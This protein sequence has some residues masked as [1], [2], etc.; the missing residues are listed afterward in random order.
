MSRPALLLFHGAPAERALLLR[1]AAEGPVVT[2][3]LDLADRPADGAD[4]QAQELGAREHRRLDLRQE[5]FERG[6]APLM[7]LGA[8][9][10]GDLLWPLA[11]EAVGLL[12]AARLGKELEAR[13]LAAA[14]SPARAARCERAW[15]ALAPDR[16]RLVSATSTTTPDPELEGELWGRRVT[17]PGLEDLWEEPALDELFGDAPSPE[18]ASELVEEIDLELEEGVLAGASGGPQDGPGLV[19]LLGRVG[20]RHALGQRL[21]IDE[22]EQGARR[23]LAV[24]APAAAI[25]EAAHAALEAA[26]LSARRRALKEPLARGYRELLRRGEHHAP[27]LRDVEAFLRSQQRPVSG[28]VRLKLYRGAALA[29]G[30]QPA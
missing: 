7:R 21:V 24:E 30:V 11:A 8:E 14:L 25:V 6:V 2:L 27:E 4:E 16:P 3:E 5:V 29:L 26:T 1:L 17:A 20:R 13:A 18:D 23:R 28:T 12:A 15:A 22:D 19:R 9:G 10:S